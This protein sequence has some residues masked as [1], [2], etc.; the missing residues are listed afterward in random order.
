MHKRSFHGTIFNYIDKLWS[1]LREFT[2]RNRTVLEVFFIM[3]YT[4]E[5][6]LLV[7]LTYRV[8]DAVE[9]SR[10]GGLK[11]RSMFLIMLRNE[12]SQT[13]GFSPMIR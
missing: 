6:A 12:Q 7:W 8:D 13:S 3:L 11:V 10:T 2:F 4:I 9:L 5:Q 1:N